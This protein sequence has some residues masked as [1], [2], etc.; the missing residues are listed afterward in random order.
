MSLEQSFESIESV[1]DNT[2]TAIKKQLS[3][4]KEFT[5]FSVF[6]GGV[7]KSILNYNSLN[8]E[9]LAVYPQWFYSARVGQPRMINSLEIRDFSK[10]PWI[11]MVLNTIKKQVENTPWDLP[12]IDSKDLNTYDEDKKLVTSFFKCINSNDETLADLFSMLVTDVGELDSGVTAKV[13]SRDSYVTGTNVEYDNSGKQISSSKALVLKPFGQRTLLGAVGVDGASILK[14]VDRFKYLKAYYQ[15]SFLHPTANPVRFEKDEIIFSLLNRKTYDVYGFS[16]VQS[17][18]QVLELLIQS[19]RFNKE[20]FA[21]NAIP[22]GIVSVLKANTHGLKQFKEQWM[23]QAKGQPHNLLFLNKEADIKTFNVSNK[24]MEWLN[25]QKWYFHLIFAV[26]GMSPAEVGFYEDSNRSTQEGQERVSVK[27]A[28]KPFY[29]LCEKV[30]NNLIREVLQKEDVPFTFEFQPENSE[31]EKVSFDN[32]MKE[33]EV[34]VVQ[35]YFAKIQV[36][37]IEVTA[38]SIKVGDKL[39]FV[40]HTTDFTDVVQSMQIEHEQVEEA[41]PGDSVGIKVGDRVRAHDKVFK[42]IEEE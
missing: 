22:D 41:K 37:A 40:G 36:A 26:F 33:I 12:N 30:A 2:D 11:Q 27:N 20:F 23:K 19:T 1:V 24:D 38:D 18:Q 5:D 8:P 7:G 29:S 14:H 10:S 6:S 34:G 4:I 42:V 28:V 39:H 31:Q 25:G 3:T 35:D 32:D 15:Y 17:V 16:P 21:R 9:K 13:F